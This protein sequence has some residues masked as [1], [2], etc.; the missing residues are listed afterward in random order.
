MIRIFLNILKSMITSMRR[1]F[2]LIYGF[3]I[4]KIV[5]NKKD[6]KTE[7]IEELEDSET[8]SE[9]IEVEKLIDKLNNFKP[10]EEDGTNPHERELGEP[11]I[12]QKFEED[13]YVYEKSIWYV[14]N[15]TVV[16]V[17][18][19]STPFDVEDSD[20]LS[21]RLNLEQRLDLAVKEERYEDAASI[22]DK[23]N[24]LNTTTTGSTNTI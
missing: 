2:L 18:I 16:K 3:D 15:G 5:V 17:K 24:M 20:L 14:D 9:F 11:D 8:D 12:I 6:E 1:K 13:G 10:I 21:N 22:R 19:I 23:L 7:L 4:P